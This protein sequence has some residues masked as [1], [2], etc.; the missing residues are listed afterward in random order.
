MG[1]SS[2]EP[3]GG[4]SASATVRLDRTGVTVS[5]LAVGGGPLGNLFSPVTDGEAGAV[6]ETARALGLRY[7]D[8]A[9]VYGMGLAE[10]RMGRALRDVVRKEFTI[11]TKVGRL[12]RSDAPLDPELFQDGQP[13]FPGALGMN[14]V[15]DF[16]AR[17][18]RLGLQESLERLGLERVDVVYLHE[19]PLE[20]LPAAID[21][22]YPVLRQ[23]RTR[24]EIDAIGVGW[25]RV[26]EMTSMVDQLDLDCL[27][28]AGRYSLLDHSALDRLLPRCLER[29]VA[30]IVGGV[31]NS[32]I[33]ADPDHNPTYDY[34]PAPTAVRDRVRRIRDICERWEVPLQAAALQFPLG[35]PAVVSVVVGMRS[36]DEVRENAAM[37]DVEIPAPF[38][39]EVKL[40][41][42]IAVDAPT[43]QR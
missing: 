36:S 28:I 13:Y 18:T 26:D 11:S 15:W 32:G 21:E 43:P 27:L 42:L 25:D 5:R 22:S 39:H 1:E 17:G 16:S 38:W 33:L 8:T 10:Q 12:L 23:M 35:H 14:P 7:F 29:D 40:A 20:H 19:P 41:G 4:A 31:Y 3:A 2:R 9:P 30:V 37:L 6:I 34:L 24:G